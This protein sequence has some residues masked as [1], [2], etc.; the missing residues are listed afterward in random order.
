MKVNVVVCTVL[1]MPPSSLPF[2][3]VQLVASE[4]WQVHINAIHCS[5]LC[6]FL[7]Y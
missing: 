6:A 7:V 2:V 3:Q 1:H 5:M 4:K